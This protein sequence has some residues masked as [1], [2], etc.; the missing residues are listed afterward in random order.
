MPLRMQNVPSLTKRRRQDLRHMLVRCNLRTLSVNCSVLA[1]TSILG[2]P[3]CFIPNCQVLTCLNQQSWLPF[4]NC[5]TTLL[6]LMAQFAFRFGN[7]SSS[8]YTLYLRKLDGKI[9][10]T[11]SEGGRLLSC[12]LFEP[13]TSAVPVVCTHCTT[14]SKT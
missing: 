10:C 6:T 1:D 5:P 7:N 3:P 4:H 9:S 11:I 12:H 2:V 13:L 14:G 8:S